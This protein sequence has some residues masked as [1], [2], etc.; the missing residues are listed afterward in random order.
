MQAAIS[1]LRLI[2][3]MAEGCTG[4]S[5][6]LFVTRTTWFLLLLTMMVVQASISA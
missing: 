1:S 5:V 6:P 4:S 3:N 2:C